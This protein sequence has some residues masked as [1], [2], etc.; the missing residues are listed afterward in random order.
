MSLGRAVLFI[1]STVGKLAHAFKQELTLVLREFSEKPQQGK[2]V[3]RSDR[4]RTLVVKKHFVYGNIIMLGKPYKIFCGGIII[5]I[6]VA[7]Y[8]LIC[9]IYYVRYFI[10]LYARIFQAAYPIAENIHHIPFP[11]FFRFT[12]L[13]SLLYFSLFYVILLQIISVFCDICVF[14][15]II[16]YCIIYYR[17][18]KRSVE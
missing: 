14:T 10:Q 9:H 6:A 8:R 7:L 5:S 15:D 4:R 13:S 17:K 16:C 11:A 2:L 18:K 3:G 12:D 1:I